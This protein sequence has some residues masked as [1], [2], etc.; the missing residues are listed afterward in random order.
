MIKIL[1]YVVEAS[2]SFIR[3]V[4]LSQAGVDCLKRLGFVEEAHLEFVFTI[5][6][7]DDR[8]RL[9][10]DLRLNNFAFSAGHDWSPS[11]LF[12]YFRDQGQ[13]SGDYIR[14]AWVDKTHTT[15]RLC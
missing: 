13:L 6:H 5:N 12:E 2:S 15:L 10:N 3:V 9:F 7:L 11:E 1:G 8:V 4:A 14:I